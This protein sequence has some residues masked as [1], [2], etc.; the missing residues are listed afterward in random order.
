M[1][2]KCLLDT[3]IFSEIRK[4]KNINV[5]T[6]AI[7]YK[8]IFKKYTISVI[9]VSEIIKGWK[10][11]NRDDRV[12]EFLQDLEQIEILPVDLKSAELL[13]LINAELE[14]NGQ[15]IGLADVLIASIAI[16]NNLILVTNNTKHYKKIQLLGYPLRIINWKYI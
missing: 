4:G 11:I 14:K 16:S 12:R 2:Q 5:I 7:A 6:Q 8:T 13:G 1:S 10:K 15:P 3:D 9:T